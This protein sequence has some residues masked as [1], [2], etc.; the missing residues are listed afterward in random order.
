MVTLKN[1]KT[2]TY[3]QVTRGTAC[4]V[5]LRGKSRNIFGNTL[6][7]WLTEIQF[8]SAESVIGMIISEI[9][10]L[11][12]SIPDWLPARY[13]TW[14]RIQKKEHLGNLEVVQ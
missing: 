14:N 7:H 4:H 10:G 2:S 8:N 6:L 9:A 12:W 3:L 5:H 13:L 1:T 11:Q